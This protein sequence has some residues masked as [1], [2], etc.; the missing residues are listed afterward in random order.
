MLFCVFVFVFPLERIERKNIIRVS[1]VGKVIWMIW[2]IFT[3]YARTH[4]SIATKYLLATHVETKGQFHQRVYAQ[5]LHVKKLLD[6]QL[7]F[8]AF[9]ICMLKAARK[10]LMKLTQQ[11]PKDGVL[12]LGHFNKDQKS[13]SVDH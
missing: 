5:L 7:S 1:S 3:S 10:M 2:L 9:G 12:E 4:P 6:L 11:G 8:C 13:Y